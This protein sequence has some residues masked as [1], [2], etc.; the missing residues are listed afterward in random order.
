MDS[1]KSAAHSKA[2]NQSS[3]FYS[4][5]RKLSYPKNYLQS[6]HAR[7]HARTPL[8]IAR[9]MADSQQSSQQQQQQGSVQSDRPATGQGEAISDEIVATIM[10][11]ERHPNALSTLASKL[12][13]LTEAQLQSNTTTGLD[14]LMTLDPSIHT[15]GY[16]YFLTARCLSLQQPEHGRFYV[17]TLHH[18]INVCDP[19]QLVYAPIR[20]SYIAKALEHLAKILNNP[21]VIIVPLATAIVKIS[22]DCNSLTSLHAPFVKVR[23]RMASNLFFSPIAATSRRR[24]QACLLAKM[25]RYPLAILD[26]DIED[27][28]PQAHA[29]S[30]KSFLLYHYYGAMIYIGNKNFDRALDFLILVLSAPAQTASAI[31][32]EAYKKFVLVSLIHHGHIPALP[33]YTFHLLEKT[34]KHKHSGYFAI[35][36]SFKERNVKKFKELL[37]AHREMLLSD[38]NMGLAKQCLQA[39]GRETIKRLTNV[40]VTLSLQEMTTMLEPVDDEPVTEEQV[41]SL[42]LEMIGNNQIHAKMT[43]AGANNDV[44]MVHFIEEERVNDTP[45]ISLRLEECILDTV[46]ISKKVSRMDQQEG[47]SKEFQMKAGDSKIEM[48]VRQV[49][50]FF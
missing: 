19:T 8:H 21:S 16:L 13:T 33:K 27:V 48:Q 32:M 2:T 49:A 44:K 9:A 43:V 42:L 34:F 36:D 28:D 20:V 14:P 45:G 25:Y 38:A 18:F 50:S 5:A 31:Q 10:S 12:A 7:K 37:E 17:Q 4:G 40:Y 47:L 29:I 15:L 35:A 1:A 39:L 22:P 24:L 41:E 46:N 23:T 11:L 6:T 3:F 26:M 30:I